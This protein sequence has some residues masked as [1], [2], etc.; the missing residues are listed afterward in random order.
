MSFWRAMNPSLVLSAAL[1]LSCLFASAAPAATAGWPDTIDLLI[2]EQSQARSCL[3]L[4][5]GSGDK[6]AIARAR[7]AYGTAKAGSD[8]AIAGFTVALV[9]GYK[10]EDLP[11]IQT[12][13]EKAGAGLQEVCNAAIKAATEAQGTKGVVDDIVKEAVAPVV[14][15]LKSAAGALWQRHVQLAKAQQDEIKGQLEA[16]KWPDF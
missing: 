11:R 14:D 15:L 13:L 3:D 16:A 5:M 1:A 12:H 2:H 8:G 6:S 10:P 4:L 9:E 7:I